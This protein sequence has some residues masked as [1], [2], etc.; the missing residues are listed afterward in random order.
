MISGQLSYY[1]YSHDRRVSL[2][3]LG[4]LSIYY[5]YFKDI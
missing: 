5:V 1:A 2:V 4:H 3:L